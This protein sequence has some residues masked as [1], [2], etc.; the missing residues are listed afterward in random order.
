MSPFN[1]ISLVGMPGAGKSTVGVLLA[2]LAGLR[3]VDTDLDIQVQ[4]EATLQEILE[5]HG[6]RYLRQAEE[7]VLLTIELDHALVSTG[8]SAVYSKASMARLKSLGPI[9]YLHTELDILEQRVAAAPPRGIAS[10][11]EQSFAQLYAE[12]TPLYEHYADHILPT[13]G[14]TPEQIASE[15]LQVLS[16]R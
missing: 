10:D 13:G 8:G 2:K 6:Y 9:L 16:G 11:S 5:K 15:A 4:E 12:R 3:F 14:K 1:T 7:K